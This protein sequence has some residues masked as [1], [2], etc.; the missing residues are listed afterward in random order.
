MR[1]SCR[2]RNTKKTTCPR[3]EWTLYVSCSG[4]EPCKMMHRRAY[5]CACGALQKNRTVLIDGS[6]VK[7]QLVRFV[8]FQL[9]PAPP[10]PYLASQFCNEACYLTRA[11]LAAVVGHCW[12]GAVPDN[13]QQLLP[14]FS[15][16][17]DS[18]RRDRYSVRSFHHK[19]FVPKQRRLSSS[20]M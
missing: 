6:H 2:N 14:R 9:D 15:G 17:N 8:Q 13:Y 4:L 7:F 5:G 10:V 20:P 1:T 18:L 3:L 16:D 19:N 11:Q 12:S